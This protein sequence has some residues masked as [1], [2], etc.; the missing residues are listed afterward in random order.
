MK[1][2]YLLIA[3][4][5]LMFTTACKK[6]DKT[7]PAK[8]YSGI[9]LEEYLADNYPDLAPID[10]TDVYVII[11]EEGDGD[12]PKVGE[13]LYYYYRGLFLNGTPFDTVRQKPAEK[14]LP[15]LSGNTPYD[16][17]YQTDTKNMG[18]IVGWY[19]GF[20]ELRRGSKAIFLIPEHRAYGKKGRGNIPPKAPLMFEVELIN[21]RR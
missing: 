2:Y 12:Y 18:H 21:D 1:K 3:V 8:P 5:F 14:D 16:F 20:G 13:E 6:D 10:T 19:V 15:D 4:A 17:T 7:K 11:T 9:S